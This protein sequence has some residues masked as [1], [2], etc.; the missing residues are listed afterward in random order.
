MVEDCAMESQNDALRADVTSVFVVDDDAGVLRGLGRLLKCEG[1]EVKQFSTPDAFLQDHD[2]SEPGCA[3]IDLSLPRQDGLTLLR[4]LNDGRSDRQVIILTGHSSITSCVE[5]MQAGAIDYLVKPVEKRALLRA[6]ECAIAR[7]RTLRDARV[8]KEAIS[9][10][11]ESLTPRERE[12]LEHVI[13]G[14]LN[15][16]IAADLGTVEKTIKVHRARMLMKMGVRSVAA[17]VHLTDSIGLE[18]RAQPRCRIQVGGA[19]RS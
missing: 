13:A 6:V 15:K 8:Y 2:P 3:I 14:R 5:A 4:R 11:L 19:P 18:P 16:Q 1:Y 12:V 17:L 10:R 7:D 9:A